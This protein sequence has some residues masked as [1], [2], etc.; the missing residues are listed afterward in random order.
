MFF[1][2]HLLSLVVCM[3]KVN[4]LVDDG[5]LTRLTELGFDLFMIILSFTDG[6]SGT[7]G[8]RV[9]G[10]RIWD[11]LGSVMFFLLCSFS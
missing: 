3:K 10:D 9:V 11:F 4:T 8:I 5:W 2:D 7:E 1:A 6:L